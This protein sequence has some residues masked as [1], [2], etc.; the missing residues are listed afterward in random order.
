M[1][2]SAAPAIINGACPSETVLNQLAA[3]LLA[4]GCKILRIGTFA[5]SAEADD[6]VYRQ[7]Q[8]DHGKD[9]LSILD[10]LYVAQPPIFFGP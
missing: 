5:V 4:R 2:F 7:L 10:A 6:I 1:K 3:A 9:D 8:Q